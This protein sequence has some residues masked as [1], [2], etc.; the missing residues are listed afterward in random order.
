MGPQ[1]GLR[2]KV[3][4]RGE[5]CYEYPIAGVDDKRERVLVD[6]SD[7]QNP[8]PLEWGGRCPSAWMGTEAAIWGAE[9]FRQSRVSPICGWPDAYT[10]PVVNAVMAMHAAHLED[11]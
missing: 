10:P 6:W 11:R 2:C 8:K 3:C 9:L 5:R 7:P 4:P 1:I